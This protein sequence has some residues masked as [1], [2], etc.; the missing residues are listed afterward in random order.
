[1]PLLKGEPDKTL[2]DIVFEPLSIL[3]D[4]EDKAEYYFPN[5]NISGKNW[6]NFVNQ[7]DLFYLIDCEEVT[8]D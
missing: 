5:L 2:Y 4:F 6:V 8:P 1:M 3:S 7:Q